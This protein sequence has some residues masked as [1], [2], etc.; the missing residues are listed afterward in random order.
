MSEEIIAHADP[1]GE[2]DTIGKR[3]PRID[4]GK[5]VTGEAIYPAD[6]HLPG[7]LFAKLKRSPYP[8]AKIRSIDTSKALELAGVFA[9]ATADDFPELEPGTAVPMGQGS[10]DVWMVGQINMARHK[11]YWVGQPVA[12]VAAT[13]PHIAEQALELI[14]IEYEVLDAVFS[15][16]EATAPGAPTLND[17]IRTTGLETPTNKPS[18]VCSRTVFERGQSDRGLAQSDATVELSVKVDT[19]HQGYIEPQAVVAQYDRDGQTT[20]WVSTQGHFTT[21]LVTAKILG[22]PQSKIRVVPLEIGGGFG[23]KV[24]IHGESVAAKLSEKC[25]RPVQLTFSREEVLQGGSGPTAALQGKVQIGA[26]KDGVI[27]AIKGRIHVD[28]GGLPDMNPGIILQVFAALYQTPNLFLEGF[29]VVT[30]K[31]RTEAY[32]APGGVQAA[33]LMEQAIDELSQKLKIDPLEFR[34][35]NASVTGSTMP[36]GTP[37]PSIGVLEIADAVAA[38]P[39]WTTPLEEGAMP[40][41]RGLAFGYWRGTSMTSACHVTISGDG[42]PMF[43][44]GSVDI[45][46]AHTSMAQVAAEQFQMSLDDVYVATGDSKSVGYTDISAASRVTR[47]MAAAVVDASQAAL[48]EL[49]KRAANLMQLTSEELI[50]DH[51][52]FRTARNN[53]PFVTVAEVMKATLTQGAI[54]CQGTSSN[55][56]FGVEVGAHVCDVEVDRDTGQI[57][58]LKYTAFQ[59]VGFA[60]N[61]P[62]VEGQIEGSVVQGLGWAISEGF[63][64]GSDGR[65]RNAS[66]LDYRIPTALDVP[67]IDTVLLQKPVPGVPYGLRG[68]GEVPIV[69]VAACVANAVARAI[70]SRV[71]Q[72]PMTPER[73]FRAM[74][75]N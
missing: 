57:T 33:F 6:F 13:D 43:T 23:G 49:K 45:S 15:I 37:F 28:A 44:L 35:R 74:K 12:A 1:H 65:L 21:E 71:T 53:G 70:G 38:H 60:L 47:T 52:A 10:C 72:M 48:T 59:D 68:V 56:P 41:G 19:A 46:G 18:N 27:N 17:S 69:P 50:Y 8:H 67:S 40:R 64:Y 34:R 51:G 11:V 5:R 75:T 66:L 36:A 29:D 73:V 55:L 25:G 63:D 54:V 24:F 2:H 26:S 62:A 32:R 14:E 7:M 9:V 30:N 39:C 61:P 22:I 31:P 20:L 58:V 4:S 16:D 42:R 3:L